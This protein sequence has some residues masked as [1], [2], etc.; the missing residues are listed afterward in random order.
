MN[1]SLSQDVA[2]C[3]ELL[4]QALKEGAHGS[5]IPLP[6]LK[7]RRDQLEADVAAALAAKDFELV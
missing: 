1:N 4:A 6:T 7:A 2:T 5:R 3:E